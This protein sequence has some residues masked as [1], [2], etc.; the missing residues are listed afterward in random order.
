MNGKNADC[1]RFK[2]IQFALFFEKVENFV[3]N[4]IFF[5]ITV[6]FQFHT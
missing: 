2:S 3:S 6:S 5:Y 1:S 4:D